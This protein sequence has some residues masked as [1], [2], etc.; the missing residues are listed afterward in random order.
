MRPLRY[1]GVCGSSAVMFNTRLTWI[2]IP[3]FSKVNNKV[4]WS[5]P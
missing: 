1:M 4:I 3:I 5:Y 2:K